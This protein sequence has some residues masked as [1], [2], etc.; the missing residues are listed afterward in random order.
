MILEKFYTN[1]FDSDIVLHH[2]GED[3]NFLELKKYVYFQ[4][5]QFDNKSEQAV[6]LFGDN[7][8]EFVV[9]FFAALFSNKEIYLLTDK[10][11]LSGLN[12]DYIIPEKSE[13]K[14]DFCFEKIDVKKTKIT[15]FTS[16]STAIPKKIT[17]SLE[18]LE[19]E[20]YSSIKQFNI[21]TNVSVYS[22]TIMPHMFGLTFF[23]MVPLCAGL[24]I[25]TLKI[26]FPEQIVKD[27]E[28]ILVSSPSFLEKMAKYD[29]NFSFAP[30]KIFTAGDKLKDNVRDFFSIK[31]DVI[32]IYGS[33]EAGT[34]AYKN[35]SNNFKAFDSVSISTDENS[36]I[37]VKSDFFM[38][39]KI[40]MEDV[41]EKISDKE[42]VLKGRCD[43]IVKVKEKRISLEEL[44]TIVKKH[45][46]VLDCYCFKY[47]DILACAV[48]TNN[49][50]LTDKELKKYLAEHCEVVPKKWRFL[51]EIPKTITGKIDK[52]FIE[53]IF[54]LNLS[55][56]FVVS[57]KVQENEAELELI[58]KKKSNF[59]KG[60]FAV[61]PILPG[62]V[63]LFY[64][65][66][67]AK[68][69]LNVD[70]SKQEAKKV[71]FTNII[72]ADT[73]VVLKLKN[74]DKNIEYSYVIDD[75]V[76]S[77]GLF[78]KEDKNEV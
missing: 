12:F 76:Y 78:V 35:T 29:I 48:A 58:F 6:V 67:F 30:K 68:H 19:A 74:T 55:Y 3:I 40:K 60:H 28:Y 13:R 49:V 54:N 11:R 45:P 47:G 53:H 59:F 73:K 41:I 46:D 52:S 5:L 1:N 65:N 51:D 36:C 50:E 23:F 56:P 72:H 77:S 10:T 34:I 15:F 39:D 21:E 22:T 7:S 17:K 63:Q 71:K 14:E 57:R 62:V 66:W 27:E 9:N 24:R 18:N 4:K 8:F 37:I 16:G 69:V 42:F 44:E 31:S 61:M 33:T 26:E 43:R 32:E 70:I 75:K 20:A 38:E 64:A 2:N 25:N